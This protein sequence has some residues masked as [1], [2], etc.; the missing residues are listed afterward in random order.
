ML[1][2]TYIKHKIR[3]TKENQHKTMLIYIDIL[4]IY[5]FPFGDHTTVYVALIFYILSLFYSNCQILRIKWQMMTAHGRKNTFVT[6]T[7]LTFILYGL[8]NRLAVSV[9]LL[10]LLL[11]YFIFFF[12][13]IRFRLMLTLALSSIFRRNTHNTRIYC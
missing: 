12:I 3:K 6:F 5:I 10:S 11:A 9:R 7:N 8:R 4:Y 1:R 13:L 2:R